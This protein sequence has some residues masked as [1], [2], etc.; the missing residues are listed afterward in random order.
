MERIAL[1]AAT[2]KGG[3]LAVYELAYN[4]RITMDE[5]AM[6]LEKMGANEH[7]E[8]SVFGRRR[9]SAEEYVAHAL[10]ASMEPVGK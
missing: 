10:N 2:K 9:A 8:K 5:A 7:C 1:Q 4:A 3:A 6:L